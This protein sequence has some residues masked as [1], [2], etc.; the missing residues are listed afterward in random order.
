MPGNTVSLRTGEPHDAARLAKF[1]A[2]A[3]ETAFGSVNTPEDMARYLD[4]SFSEPAIRAQLADPASTFLLAE[5]G[6]RIVGYVMLHSG[7]AP[8]PVTGPSPIE[9]V[10]IYVDPP[11]IGSGLGSRLMAAS[12]DEAAA[13]GAQT[14]WLGVWERN[15]RAIAFYER[16]GFER[17]GEK[18]F[19]LGEDVQTD[20]VMAKRLP[21]QARRKWGD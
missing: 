19:V 18:T 1:G 4:E 13:Q 16:W 11:A 7:H 9:L 3:F 2:L 6:G 12:L 14:I 10:R 20:H 8:P 21:P 15:G 5:D 17:V